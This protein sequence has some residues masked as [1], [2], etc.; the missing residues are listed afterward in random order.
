MNNTP[1]SP[2]RQIY[3]DYA[4]TTP[5]HPQ[6]LEAML[7]CAS[8]VYGN[9]SSLH[10]AGHAAR[11]ALDEA[12][13]TFAAGLNVQPEEIVFTGSGSE[14]D[15]LALLGAAQRLQGRG[16]HV[17]TSCIEH[18]AVLE[19]CD[20]L[21]RL[22]FDV[23]RLPVDSDGVV[24][25]E[26]LRAALR[27]DTILVSIMHANNEIGTIQPISALAEIA[28]E[29]G[30]LFHTDAVQ[31]AGQ[32]ALDVQA[33]GVDLLTLS[34]HKF[35][36]PKGVG[37][38]VVREGVA[39][40]PLVHGGSQE[41]YRRAGTENLPGIVGAAK[42][43]ALALDHLDGEALRLA[44]LRDALWQRIC[45]GVPDA[46]LNGHP[47]R[48]L[49]NNLNVSLKD[50]EAEGMLLRLSMAGVAASMGSACNSESIEPSHVIEALALPPDWARGTLR[51]TVGCGTTPDDIAQAADHVVHIAA[52][53]R[54][55]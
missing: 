32:I 4:A 24:Q 44:A 37:A 25:P 30:A 46:R 18:H 39:L 53:M 16:R 9:P 17:I 20:Y 14:A 3:L 22:G 28:H 1:R 19:T 45:E 54:R 36:G 34:A 27:P 12:R 13:A 50:I 5:I 33:L 43:F 8:A 55:E 21:E 51:F 35:Y 52:D 40:E 38:L 23:T 10:F 6:A 42:A 2:R 41:G 26:T 48:R 7:G 29:A 11:R 15:N 47:T 49:P 31:T